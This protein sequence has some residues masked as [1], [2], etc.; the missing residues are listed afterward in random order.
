MLIVVH[1][2]LCITNC[3]SYNNKYVIYWMLLHAV[4]VRLLICYKL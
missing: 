4:A 3:I 2:L 1:Q